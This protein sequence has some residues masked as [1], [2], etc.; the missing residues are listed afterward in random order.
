MSI[1]PTFYRYQDILCLK[2][3]K[4]KIGNNHKDFELY[5]LF[6]HNFLYQNVLIFP[7]YLFPTNAKT[8]CISFSIKMSRYSYYTFR[9]HEKSTHFDLE[10]SVHFVL[11]VSGYFGLK[12]HTRKIINIHKNI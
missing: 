3:H 6:M 4:R 8:S 11:G 12:N 7:L 2:N 10:V 9:L 5:Q 1:L